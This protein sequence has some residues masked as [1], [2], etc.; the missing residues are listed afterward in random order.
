MVARR[1]RHYGMNW[2]RA[3]AEQY[4]GLTM[5]TLMIVLPGM[6]AVLFSLNLALAAPSNMQDSSRHL[7]EIGRAHV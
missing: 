1:L 3:L 4:G 2:Y 6:I 5:K 7:Y